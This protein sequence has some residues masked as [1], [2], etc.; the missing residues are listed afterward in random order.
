MMKIAYLVVTAALFTT[1]VGKTTEMISAR[2]ERVMAPAA[3]SQKDPADSLYREARAALGK[4]DYAK[5]AELFRKITRQYPNSDY[6]G[7]AL[8]Y[9][10]F[11]EYRIGG[12]DRL[13][14][15][16]QSLTKIENNYPA[17][18]KRSDGRDSACNNRSDV[19]RR[20]D[21]DVHVMDRSEPMPR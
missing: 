2:A 1:G 8:Y 16:L 12:S 15:A 5:A 21:R 17:L 6:A 7:E 20:V 11:A 14:S 4:G 19:A 10:A 9:Q 18:S 13:R 3:W